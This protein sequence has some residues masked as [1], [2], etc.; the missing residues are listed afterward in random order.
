MSFHA[1][2]SLI[3]CRGSLVVRPPGIPDYFKIYQ[4]SCC[5]KQSPHKH[6]EFAQSSR[7]LQQ[8]QNFSEFARLHV[9]NSPVYRSF[10][11]R[12]QR[13]IHDSCSVHL[14]IM[15]K[16]STERNNTMPLPAFLIG[17]WLLAEQPEILTQWF[18]FV[19]LLQWRLH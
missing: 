5:Q 15:S 17:R 4:T 18:A 2:G 10:I 1:P 14:A 12:F 16:P 19:S 7:I 13:V 6:P 8:E 9:Q 3:K 11:P